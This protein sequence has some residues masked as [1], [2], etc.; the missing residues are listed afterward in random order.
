MIFEATFYI[1][2]TV[3]SEVIMAFAQTFGGRLDRMTITDANLKSK[4]GKPDAE[5]IAQAPKAKYP[6]AHI[7]L[8]EKGKDGNN[9]FPLRS[10]MLARLSAADDKDSMFSLIAQIPAEDESLVAA[11]WWR[12]AAGA[13]LNA[14]HAYL[15]QWPVR[16]I[17]YGMFAALTPDRPTQTWT[18][19]DASCQRLMLEP[20]R[21]R[22]VLEGKMLRNVLPQNFMTDSLAETIKEKLR[23]TGLA[24]DGFDSL[25]QNRAV[26]T[27]PGPEVQRMA[28]R[29]LYREGLVWEIDWID[30]AGY[31]PN[32]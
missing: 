27:L 24:T 19:F 2:H 17:N 8:F 9:N 14:G 18:D 23:V 7:Q 29:I 32:R 20:D 11:D 26:W 10:L 5:K 28:H 15:M 21:F 13:G 4:S 31:L 3:S 6:P 22:P 25:P 30:L 1:D 16:E 12:L